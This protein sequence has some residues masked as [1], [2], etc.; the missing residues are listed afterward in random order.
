MA[1]EDERWANFH[2]GLEDKAALSKAWVRQDQSVKV[3]YFIA[4]IQQIEVDH[5][6]CVALGCAL[7]PEFFFDSLSEGEEVER[8]S[9]VADFSDGIV[10]KGRTW[11]AQEGFSLI[12]RSV[13]NLGARGGNSLQVDASCLQICEAV[14][15]I[16]A[17]GD[18]DAWH[19]SVF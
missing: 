6:G 13:E 15:E 9:R 8:I 19:I 10:E 16:R 1:G 11:R 12:G 3:E 2:Q 18:A 14:T 7:T 17:E 4:E 5:P